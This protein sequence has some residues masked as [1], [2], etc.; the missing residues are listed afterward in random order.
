MSLQPD[1]AAFLEL[2]EFGRLTGSSR[3]MHALSVIEARREFEA[4]SLIIDPSPPGELEVIDLQLPTRDSVSLPARLYRRPSTGP[5][6]PVI[7]YFHGGGYVVGSLDSH[8][9]VCRRLACLGEFAVLAPTYRRAPEH[10]FPTAQLDAQDAVAWLAGQASVLGL[11]SNRVVFAGDS[12]GASLAAGLAIA[13][14]SER[15]GLALQPIAQMLFYPVTDISQERDSHQRYAEGFLLETPSLRWFYQHYAPN[16][17]DRLD[18]RASPLLTPD[19]PTLAPAYIGLATHDPLYD[20]GLAYAERLEA[21]GT[22]VTL[23][24][25]Q[26]LT[27]DYLRMSG[28]VPVVEGIYRSVGEWL[29]ALEGRAGA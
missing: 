5:D 24:I 21:A 4:S 29:L 11:D 19:M 14:A 25:E 10:A 26:G 12:V 18:W 20:E 9:A 16:P 7:L 8:E 15:V 1:L 23:S 6:Q 3:A 28:I 13:A 2:V 17:A 27:H 22:A